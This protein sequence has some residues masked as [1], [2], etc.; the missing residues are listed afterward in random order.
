MKCEGRDCNYCCY[1]PTC[2]SSD[3]NE[4]KRQRQKEYLIIGILGCM[5]GIAIN[6]FIP[7]RK[8]LKLGL[9]FLIKNLLK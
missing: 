5:A 9:G 7:F 3:Y 2:P 1:A 8:G 6:S 4:E